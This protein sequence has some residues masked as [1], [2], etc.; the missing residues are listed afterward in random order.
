[1][2]FS[3]DCIWLPHLLHT[4]AP[5]HTN[6]AATITSATTAWF[7]HRPGLLSSGLWTNC[8]SQMCW[9]W[10]VPGGE[11]FQVFNNSRKIF[12]FK[13][14]KLLTLFLMAYQK[15]LGISYLRL[16]LIKVAWSTLDLWAIALCSF[17][18]H[19]PQGWY[20]WLYSSLLFLLVAFPNHS[21]LSS[22][23]SEA[24]LISLALPFILWFT[25]FLES[26]TS[27][28]FPFPA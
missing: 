7:V 16:D 18:S 28:Q 19:S 25:V 8:K 4:R 15:V 24:K 9:Y 21:S 20:W 12:Y 3:E 11:T 5:A 23:G 1:M 22:L 14:N 26:S 17:K 6:M 10:T 27:D 2:N 13:T